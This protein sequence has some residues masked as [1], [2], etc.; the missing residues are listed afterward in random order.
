MCLLF[1]KIATHNHDTSNTNTGNQSCPLI[2][3]HQYGGD[4]PSTAPQ[5]P[6]T[7]YRQAPLSLIATSCLP[8][9]LE[10][11]YTLT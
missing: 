5:H 6:A 3:K 4:L 9:P 10:P 8:L 7:Q 2:R 11:H 1:K